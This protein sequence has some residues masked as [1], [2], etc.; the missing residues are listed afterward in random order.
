MVA[1][2]DDVVEMLNLPKVFTVALYEPKIANRY[3]MS[4]D[5]DALHYR[6]KSIMQG[7]LNR[8]DLPHVR[9]MVGEICERLLAEEGGQ[10]TR[11][12][13]FAGWRRR[14]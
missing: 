14:R 12:A 5:D 8:D 3:L 2:F 11:S 10:M 9:A 13:V 1:L 4:H 7:F 6:E